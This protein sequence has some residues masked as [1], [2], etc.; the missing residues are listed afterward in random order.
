MIQRMTK[1]LTSMEKRKLVT[2]SQIEALRKLVTSEVTETESRLRQ[3]FSIRLE[4]A[5]TP[6]GL[7]RLLHIWRPASVDFSDMYK[8]TLL[9]VSTTD[10]RFGCDFDLFK[11]ELTLYF[12]APPET[13]SKSMVIMLPG[14]EL[15]LGTSLPGLEGRLGIICTDPA[16][17]VFSDLILAFITKPH[18]VY[19]GNEFYV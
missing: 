5:Q 13:V 4:A 17:K 10:G 18:E 3:Y 8:T 19:L 9:Q 6:P 2:E 12:Y 11:Y 7:Y 14:S 15:T 1:L 16:G